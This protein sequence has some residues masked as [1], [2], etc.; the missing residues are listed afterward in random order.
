MAGED[1]DLRYAK[2]G[3]YGI[4]KPYV[5]AT[6]H[7][8]QPT[9]KAQPQN[10]DLRYAKPGEQGISSPYVRAATPEY[11]PKTYQQIEA[12]ARQKEAYYMAL[13]SEAQASGK[14]Q[15]GAFVVQSQADQA[16]YTQIAA[17]YKAAETSQYNLSQME[18]KKAAY[19]RDNMIFGIIPNPLAKYD[20]PISAILAKSPMRRSADKLSAPAYERILSTPPTPRNAYIDAGMGFIVGAAEEARDRPTKFT[21]NLGIGYA[22]GKLF[23]AGE[24][25]LAAAAGKGLIS[26][27]AATNIPKIAAIGMGAVYTGSAGIQVLS[28]PTPY[29]KGERA[30]KIVMGEVVPLSIGG[31]LAYAKKGDIRFGFTT[32]QKRTEIPTINVMKATPREIVDTTPEIRLTEGMI[33][34]KGGAPDFTY[35]GALSKREL[36]FVT[37]RYGLS[38][39]ELTLAKTQKLSLNQILRLRQ[40]TERPQYSQTRPATTQKPIIPQAQ[41]IDVIPR[42]RVM[43][44]FVPDV[45]STPITAVRTTPKTLLITSLIPESA[46][47][48][49]VTPKTDQITREDTKTTTITR[50]IQ[51]MITT[52]RKVQITPAITTTPSITRLTQYRPPSLSTKFDIPKP[53]VPRGG[54]GGFSGLIGGGVYGRKR[55]GWFKKMSKINPVPTV[56]SVLGAPQKRRG[57]KKKSKK[58]MDVWDLI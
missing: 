7:P 17:A 44:G 24:G 54:I 14:I 1:I 53:I 29:R 8:S 22:G 45:F 9:Q 36:S 28:E 40:V 33:S 13:R 3:E 38:P 56:S 25:A 10:D 52:P 34:F 32:E 58:E 16:Q 49:A 30:G 43:S 48:T 47:S 11:T 6:P 12:E 19:E 5:A 4:K 21:I 18:Q 51:E 39:Y 31:M 26:S 35:K 42:V 27:K 20:K 46:I 37:Q 57:G 15:E 41:A 55:G 2:P 50:I 23:Q